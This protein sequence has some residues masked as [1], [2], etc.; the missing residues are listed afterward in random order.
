MIKPAKWVIKVGGIKSGKDTTGKNVVNQGVFLADRNKIVCH[1]YNTTC[2][3]LVNGHGYKHFIDIFVKPFFKAKIDAFPNE[4]QKVNAEVIEKLGPKTVK[5]S[6]IKFKRGSSFPCNQCDYAFKSI[7]SLGNH[8]QLE[9]LVSFNSS[10]KSIEPR[11][12][13]RNNSF[14]SSLTIEDITVSDSVR[15]AGE[16]VEKSEKNTEVPSYPVIGFLVTTNQRK[17]N[18][19]LNTSMY[20][21]AKKLM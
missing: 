14:T 16:I 3:I 19:L 21:L 15:D 6:S 20:T 4:I 13:T 5:R 8:K 12:S 18:Y 11:H 7:S 1:L 10:C 2:L 17:G 9:H